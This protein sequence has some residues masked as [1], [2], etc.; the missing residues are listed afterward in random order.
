MPKR[1]WKDNRIAGFGSK[2]NGPGWVRAL[3]QKVVRFVEGESGFR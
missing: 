3:R 2:L 1:P